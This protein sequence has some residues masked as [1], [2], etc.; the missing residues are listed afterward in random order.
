MKQCD[1]NLLKMKEN[2]NDYQKHRVRKTST[3]GG[4]NDGYIRYVCE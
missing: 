2:Q 3:T 4:C 1:E